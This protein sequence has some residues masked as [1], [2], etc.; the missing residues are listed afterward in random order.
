VTDG[1][2]T[3]YFKFDII[4]GEV[5]NSGEI[6]WQ[7]VK[8]GEVPPEDLVKIISPKPGQKLS[9]TPVQ[10]KWTL[11]SEENIDSIDIWFDRY[12][13]FNMNGGLNNPLHLATLGGGT[14]F[15]WRSPNIQTD[16][17]KILVIV[18]YMDGTEYYGISE[19]FSIVK[20]YSFKAYK[21]APKP[22]YNIGSGIS[23]GVATIGA[24]FH[25]PRLPFLV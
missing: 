21:K 25:K 23:Q 11:P 5:G 15:S 12:G 8:G 14:T 20:G 17:A 1:S 9:R 4:S 19:N 6:S 7:F 3:F 13:D 18:T 2:H 24:W 22:V 16:T 10:I